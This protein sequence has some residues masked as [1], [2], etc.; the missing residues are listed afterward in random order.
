MENN[1]LGFLN[2]LK[3]L[4]K[5]YRKLDKTGNQVAFIE[6]LD[7]LFARHFG[8]GSSENSGMSSRLKKRSATIDSVE[9][10]ERAWR[11]WAARWVN[12]KKKK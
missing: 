5:H 4:Q 3:D 7:P 8:A 12:K 11:D 6:G 9:A 10:L 2:F 1:R